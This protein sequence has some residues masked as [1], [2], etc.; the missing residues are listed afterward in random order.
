MIRFDFWDEWENKTEIE[1]RAINLVKRAR[2]LVIQVVPKNVLVAIYIKGSFIR[3]EMKEGS[4]VDMVPIVTEDKYQGAVF[5]VNRPEIDPVM[6]VPLSIRELQKNQ[7]ST[8]SDH[9]LDLRAEPDLFL[10]KLLECRLVYGTPLNPK[11]FPIREEKEILKA[12]IKKI[13]EGY[14]PA[15]KAGRIGFKP[16]LKEVFWL[17]ELEQSI[18]GKNVTHSFA[19]IVKSVGKKQHIIHRAFAFRKDPDKS[20][21]EKKAFIQL[22]KKHLDALEEE[23]I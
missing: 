6:V 4:D 3:R 18:R 12:A 19:G 17:V 10:K 8:K 20:K 21:A 2:E 23:L 7:L 13:K 5:S 1:E 16:L 11:E 14:I 22:L 9:T 15:H